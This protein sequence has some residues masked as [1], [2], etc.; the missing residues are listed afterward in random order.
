[1]RNVFDQL[2]KDLLDRA[3]TPAGRVERQH[4]VRGEVQAVDAWFLPAPGQS[5]ALAACG[6]LGRMGAQPTLFEAFHRPPGLDDL[7]G[8]VHKQ[9]AV[10]LQLRREA[11]AARHH[12]ADRPLFPRLWVISAGVPRTVIHAYGFKRMSGWPRGFWRRK[13]VDSIGLVVVS[14]LPCT[15][16]TLMLRLMGSGEVLRQAHVEVHSLPADAWERQVAVPALNEL[17][18]HVPRN[19]S[20]EVKE[21]LMSTRITHEEWLSEIQRQALARGVRMAIEVACD[22]FGIRI[23]AKRRAKLDALDLPA[24]EALLA[25]IRRE[26]RWPRE[27]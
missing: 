24:L 21:F 14:E 5:A 11:R 2:A 7:R 15:R 13:K 16:D 6:L 22:L 18:L 1:M 17:R 8:C 23:T 26:R 20:R 3:L 9:L 19:P 4:E 10:H 25:D 27:P 12:R